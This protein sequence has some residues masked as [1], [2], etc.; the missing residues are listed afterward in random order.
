[1]ERRGRAKSGPMFITGKLSDHPWPLLYAPRKLGDY[2]PWI[3]ASRHASHFGAC[4][5][6][7]ANHEVIERTEQ[8]A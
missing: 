4:A 1:M 6:R 3:I 2:L 8:S 7:Y 5:I